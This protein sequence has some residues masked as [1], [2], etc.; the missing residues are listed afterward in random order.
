[1]YVF[2]GRGY[3]Q[4]VTPYRDELP[5]RPE[6]QRFV[7]ENWAREARVHLDALGLSPETPVT[8]EFVAAHYYRQEKHTQLVAMVRPPEGSI[9]SPRGVFDVVWRKSGG[10]S[11]KKPW[12]VLPPVLPPPPLHPATQPSARVVP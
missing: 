12:A 6:W 7:E 8:L 1:M 2:G 11:S 9:R 3:R 4:F 5:V 10:A